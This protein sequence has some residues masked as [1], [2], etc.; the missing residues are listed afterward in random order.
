MGSLGRFG[1][2]LIFGLLNFNFIYS[3]R[4]AECA[5][6]SV[7]RRKQGP[8]GL[9]RDMDVTEGHREERN[10]KHCSLN[11]CALNL[12]LRVAQHSVVRTLFV[13]VKHQAKANLHGGG[14]RAWNKDERKKWFS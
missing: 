11:L 1:T 6:T 2:W 14:K 3:L 12:Y 9:C 13:F 7:T 5:N 4:L 10:L 8:C